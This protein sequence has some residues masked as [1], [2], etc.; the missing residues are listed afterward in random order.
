M[1]GGRA[2]A[3]EIMRG[4]PAVKALIRDNKVHQI[5]SLI[6]AGQK[7]GMM[8]MNQSLYNLYMSRQISLEDAFNYSRDFEEL[9]RMIE[10]KSAM[11]A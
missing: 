6:Q 4:T 8:T 10:Q 5:Y 11:V 9:E 2:L 1:K 7:Y 3:L